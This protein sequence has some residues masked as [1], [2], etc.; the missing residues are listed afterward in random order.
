[1]S[2]TRKDWAALL[3]V[4]QAF[5][6]GE[7]VQR[8]DYGGRWVDTDAMYSLLHG[9]KFRVKPAESQMGVW[10]RDFTMRE[11]GTVNGAIGSGT[12]R[13]EGADTDTPKWP[14]VHGLQFTSDAVFTPNVR[15]KATAAGGSPLSE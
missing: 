1:M 14:S 4:L 5:V 6:A 15:A 13:W 7:P 8:L 11:P 10:T 2:G 3:P 9:G 12:L